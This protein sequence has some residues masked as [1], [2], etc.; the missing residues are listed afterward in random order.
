MASSRWWYTEDQKNTNNKIQKDSKKNNDR[1]EVIYMKEWKFNVLVNT[2]I[3]KNGKGF[4]FKIV[5][6]K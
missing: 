4:A 3:N 1:S 6:I 5:S 2:E